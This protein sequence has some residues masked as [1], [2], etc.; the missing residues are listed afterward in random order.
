MDNCE[1]SVVLAVVVGIG[2]LGL[3]HAE[4]EELAVVQFVELESDQ[5]SHRRDNEEHTAVL[6]LVRKESVVDGFFL[7]LCNPNLVLSWV[8]LPHFFKR[9]FLCLVVIEFD[10]LLVIDSFEDKVQ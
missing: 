7:L 10:K 6:L 1:P 3:E 9:C 8:F 2:P 4:T 5:S